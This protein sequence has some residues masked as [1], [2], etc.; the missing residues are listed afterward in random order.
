MLHLRLQASRLSL[1]MPPW[2]R[3]FQ[4]PS[5]FRKGIA[6]M[7]RAQ[8]LL[9]IVLLMT[10]VPV[11]LAQE[12]SSFSFQ[13]REQDM[14]IFVDGQPFAT[15]VW[16]DAKT[17]R[18]YFKQ[19]Y[20]TGGKVQLTRHHPPGPDDFDDHETFHPGIWWGFGDIGGNDYWRLKTKVVGGEFTEQP[21]S[22]AIQ[23]QFTVRN[24]LLDASGKRFCW[25]TC[26][27]VFVKQRH[28]IL[29]VC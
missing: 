20:G 12:S 15:Y 28:G 29:I 10:I 21:K 27:Y 18:P 26:R 2:W 14:D 11:S 1:K 24:R 6:A 22:E 8:A 4:L 19:I 13:K 25:Q 5:N 7:L 3:R 17:T 9:W 23:A 16:E